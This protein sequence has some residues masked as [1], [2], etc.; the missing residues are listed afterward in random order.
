MKKLTKMAINQSRICIKFGQKG[1]NSFAIQTYGIIEDW[2]AKKRLL[3]EASA[4]D[5]FTE[6]SFR[7]C[8]RDRYFGRVQ[9]E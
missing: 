8:L 7:P 9:V 4:G 5:Q 1:R 2:R 6:E 3:C